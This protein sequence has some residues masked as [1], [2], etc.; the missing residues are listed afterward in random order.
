MNDRLLK[1]NLIGRLVSLKGT[2]VRASAMRPLARSMQF[3]CD[4]CGEKISLSF[5]EGKC[6][7]PQKCPSGGSPKN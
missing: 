3:E 5:P 7:V 1:S 6:T 2:V 4:K